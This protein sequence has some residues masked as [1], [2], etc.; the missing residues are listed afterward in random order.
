MYEWGS[1]NVKVGRWDASFVGH[2]DPHLRD[3][4]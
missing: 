1:G 4:N 2:E 3:G